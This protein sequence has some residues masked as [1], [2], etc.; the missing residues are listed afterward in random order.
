MTPLSGSVINNSDLIQYSFYSMI[1]GVWRVSSWLLA[2]LL[3]LP[4]ATV[5]YQAFFA[6]GLGFTQLWQLGLP[7]YLIHSAIIAI[8][9]LFF[10]LLFGL[11]SAWFIAM[12]RFPG[13]RVL[14]WALCLPLAMPAFL[15]AY[16]YTDALRHLSLWLR[17]GG[18]LIA[19]PWGEFHVAGLPVSLG[20]VSLVLALV[21]YP[22]IYLLVREALVKQPASLIH[23]ARLLNQTRAQVFRRLCLPIAL[24]AIACG[25][26]LVVVETLGDYGAASYLGIP[27]MTTQVLDIWQ[28]QGDLGAAARLGVLILPAIFI[29]MFLVNLWRRKQKIYQAQANSSLSIPPALGGWRSRAVRS[30]CW[31]VVCLAFLLPVLYLLFLAIRHMMSIWDMAFL[32]AVMNSLLASATATIIITLMALSF[33]F[34]TR[35]AGVF[36]NQTPVRLVSLSFALPGAVLAV[37]LFTLLS[38]VDRGI[39]FLASAAGLPTADALLAGSLFILMVAYSV[40]FGRLMLDSLERSMEAI[41]RSLDSASLVL[42]ASPLSRWSRV[43]I[44]LLRRSVFIGALLIFTESMK[45]L[46]IS[47]LLRPFGID[48]LAT[49]VFR[50]TASE[51]AASFAFP[52]LVLVAVGLIPVFWLNRALNIKG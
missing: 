5:F 24:P 7:T 10:S 42:G 31:G 51:Q 37:G 11:P 48:T 19:S 13:H 26:A 36:A 12:Y 23:S 27:T 25:S 16:L 34:Y 2:G 43:H 29:L 20:C 28:G 1:S 46:N 3:L 18:L 22:Y 40:K 35:T 49:Y 6:G 17:E 50:F 9:T 4:L 39:N 47:L 14:Q 8:G 21:L 32:H 15:L 30:Y 38:L 33:I 45:E 52:A 44:P 41:P